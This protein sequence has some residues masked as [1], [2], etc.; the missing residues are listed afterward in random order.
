MFIDNVSIAKNDAVEPPIG[1]IDKVQMVATE[2]TFSV[3]NMNGAFVCKI[4][5]SRIG[6]VK[7][8]L[9][10]MKVVKGLY[11]V[12]DGSFNRVISVR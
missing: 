10:S 4:V 11:V 7:A 12:K 9:S 8:R 5:A 2:R 6:D 1:I 3:Y